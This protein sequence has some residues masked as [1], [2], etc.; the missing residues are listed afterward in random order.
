MITSISDTA[1][2]K[3]NWGTW[4]CTETLK[5]YASLGN[6]DYKK[7]PGLNGALAVWYLC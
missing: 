7:L 1:E 2:Q 6:T 3:N 5:L 4:R